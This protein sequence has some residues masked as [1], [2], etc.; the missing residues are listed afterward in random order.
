MISGPEKY[1][2]Y[3]KKILP[4]ISLSEVNNYFENYIKNENQILQ[5]KG[6][7]SIKNLPD[8][9]E[10]DKIKKIVISK[11]IE[12]YDYELKKIELIKGNLKDQK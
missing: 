1:I 8:E 6:P 10:I 5:I 4:T 7:S 11:S 9:N 2:E 3:S 12:K